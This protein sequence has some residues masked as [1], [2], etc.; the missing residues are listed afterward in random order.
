[1]KTPQKDLVSWNSLIATFAQGGCP[2]EALEL[3]RVMEKENV[4]PNDVTM[5]GVLSACTKKL[6]LEFGR[7]VCSYIERNEINV[8]LTLSNAMLVYE[9]WE[10]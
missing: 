7:C 8:N 1:M 6:D 4:K 5:V 10:L 3:F 2:E 9:M